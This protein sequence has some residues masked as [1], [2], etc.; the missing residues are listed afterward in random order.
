MDRPVASGSS[1]LLRRGVVIAAALAVVAVLTY[2][3]LR[4]GAAPGLRVAQASL[5]ISVAR[6]GIFEDVLPLRGSVLPAVTNYLDTIESGRVEE[7][8]VEDGTEVAAGAPLVRMSNSELELA[9]IARESEVTQQ[10]TNLNGFRMQLEQTR[11]DHQR[12][13]LESDWQIRRLTRLGERQAPLVASGVVSA[14]DAEG[15]LDEL[16]YWKEKRI[17]IIEAK[18]AGEAQQKHR[19]DYL[20]DATRQLEGNLALARKNLEGLRVSAPIAGK[21]TAFDVK[22]GQ[23]VE[24]GKRIGQID[25]TGDH[26][27]SV[28]IDEFYLPRVGV[29][30]QASLQADGRTYGLKVAKVNAQVVNGQFTADLVFLGDMPADLRRGRTFS[31]ALALSDSD[32]RTALIVDNG[33]FYEVSGGAWLF[34]V[35]ADGRSAAKR[36]V[37]G[38]RRNE[39]MLEVTAGL[40]P[41]ERVIVSSYASY[42]NAERLIIEP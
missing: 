25:A 34:V 33:P 22:R 32:D 26:K 6:N 31:V 10:V 20:N 16:A 36:A 8:L 9:V 27:L 18:Q 5:Q 19:L 3:V 39:K 2:Q 40:Q 21:L 13:L 23:Y 30:L 14:S 42:T 12:A 7:V 17:A 41:G 24:K 1:R 38:G 28:A 29:G 35:A 15:T 4:V 11:L 37:Q